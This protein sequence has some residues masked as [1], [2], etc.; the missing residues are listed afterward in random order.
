M[1]DGLRSG[2]RKRQKK[3]TL[4]SWP[5]KRVFLGSFG[6]KKCVFD[7]FLGAFRYCLMRSH[8]RCQS[9]RSLEVQIVKG[10]WQVEGMIG[11][12]AMGQKENPNGGHR[13]LS[14]NSMYQPGFFRYPFLTQRHLKTW[15][16]NRFSVDLPTN[17]QK[18]PWSWLLFRRKRRRVGYDKF[19]CEVYTCGCVV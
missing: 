17:Q 12:L 4:F 2:G 18:S 19:P 13:F 3:R 15:G 6:G 14:N 11:H 7:G 5:K 9:L 10:F 1:V 8:L 16:F